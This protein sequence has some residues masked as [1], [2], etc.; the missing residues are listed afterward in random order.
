MA[1]KGKR[2]N[3]LTR[4][5]K[6]SIVSSVLKTLLPHLHDE[7]DFK[8]MMKH[9]L[10]SMAREQPE[11]KTSVEYFSENLDMQC[12]V[13]VVGG[14]SS[15]RQQHGSGKAVHQPLL[16]LN[17][18]D[19]RMVST[20]LTREQLSKMGYEL[21]K[22]RWTQLKKLAQGS[23]AGSEQKQRNV[24]GRPSMLHS[25]STIDLVRA[26]VSPH[27]RESSSI[28][29]VGQGRQKK[30]VV[31]N[32]LTMPR[33]R[34]WC[35]NPDLHGNLSW[36]LFH[37]VMRVHFPHIRNPRRDTDVCKHCKHFSSQ[38]LPRALKLV[39]KVRSVLEQ[40]CGGYFASY[41]SP[42]PVHHS[43]ADKHVVKEVR[44]LMRF[45]NIRNENAPNDPLR[46][47]MS[48]AQR[49]SLHQAEAAAAHKL[50]PNLEIL[51]A[52]EWHQISATRQ[53]GFVTA[54]RQGGLP[55]T[56]LL[57]QMDFKENIKYPMSPQ[58]TSEDWHAQNK[59]S[60]T[61]FGANA[62]APKR[63]V[64]FQPLFFSACSSE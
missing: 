37:R 23:E 61:V 63:L 64:W 54:L 42:T 60:L 45:I 59:L 11:V 28:V 5:Y 27:L 13:S 20:G 53:T 36:T 16:S 41:D 43:E 26:N 14:L 31:A 44:A 4:Q 6:S 15:L 34:I 1:A 19:C 58:E 46:R 21:T 56:S 29:V 18:L 12:I 32:L 51:E 9:L 22:H 33:Y 49:L 7:S 39:R 3:D 30:M 50:K 10:G 52:Y 62:I 35:Q 47:N 2:W 57:L 8:N 48:G 24:G 40:F 25:T 55:R 38:L 17:D